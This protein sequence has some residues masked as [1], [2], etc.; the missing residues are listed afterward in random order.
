MFFAKKRFIPARTKSLLAQKR[1]RPAKTNCLL[2]GRNFVRRKRNIFCQE[3]LFPAHNIG[4]S[5]SSMIAK[6][7]PELNRPSRAKSSRFRLD[8]LN[9]GFFSNFRLQGQQAVF[10]FGFDLVWIDSCG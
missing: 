2:P 3:E 5:S 1:F 4:C 7:G 6:G 9:T 10:D 8:L